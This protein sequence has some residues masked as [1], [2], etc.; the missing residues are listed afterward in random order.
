MGTQG[1]GSPLNRRRFLQRT[2]ELSAG[3][4][5]LEL[6]AAC[7]GGSTSTT[8]VTA[9]VNTLPPSTNPGA[10]YVFNQVV[11]DFEQAHPHE[12]IVGKNDPYD[13]TTYFAKLA[14]G[15]L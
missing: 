9:T 5:G 8:T 1:T 6:L 4:V 7:G 10:V 11:K 3:V 14:A 13:P 2:F 12:H 15:Q